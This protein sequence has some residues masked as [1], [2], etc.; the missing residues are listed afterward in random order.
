MARYELIALLDPRL[1]QEDVEALTKNIKGLFDGSALKD[2][3]DIGLLPLEYA[4][5]G[6]DRAYFLS[7]LLE[8]E[9][10]VVEDVRKKLALEKGVLRFFFYRM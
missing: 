8:V 7:S 10:Q 4:V 2:E 9:P 6:V 1:P 3:D 5:K